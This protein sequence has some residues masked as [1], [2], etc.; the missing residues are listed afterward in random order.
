VLGQGPTYYY[1]GGV[2]MDNQEDK[3]LLWHEYKLHIEL[4]NSYLTTCLIINIFYYAF[5]GAMLSYYFKSDPSKFL[6]SIVYL[7]VLGGFLLC[8]FFETKSKLVVY[9]DYVYFIAKK[10]GI[11]FIHVKPTTLIQFAKAVTFM[12]ICNLIGLFVLFFVQVFK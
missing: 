12:M 3:E 9:G 10:I 1:S 7:F 5:T 11:K 6:V 2:I 4:F 8:I